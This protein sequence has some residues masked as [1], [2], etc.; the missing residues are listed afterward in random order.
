VRQ[1]LRERATSWC[2]TCPLPGDLAPGDLVAVPASGAYHRSMANNYNHVPR[3]PVVAV[4]D[5]AA[6]VVV[7]RETEDDLMRLDVE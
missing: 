2:T 4:R 5:G 1:A 7:R 6:R 3:P